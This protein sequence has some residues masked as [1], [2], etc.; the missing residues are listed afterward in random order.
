MQ[1]Y[2][3]ACFK[4]KQRQVLKKELAGVI[5]SDEF[6]ELCRKLLIEMARVK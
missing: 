3:I 6:S 2:N 5:G 1:H 4:E